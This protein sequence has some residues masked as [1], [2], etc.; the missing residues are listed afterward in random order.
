[1][2]QF[3]KI[4]DKDDSDDSHTIIN[5]DL[6]KSWNKNKMCFTTLKHIHHFYNS[7]CYLRKIYLRINDP[8]FKIIK[9]GTN[10]PE[11]RANI[12][13]FG[14]KYEL[15]NVDTIKKFNLKL[16]RDLMNIAVINQNID[17][18]DL[19]KNEGF[20]ISSISDDLI[21]YAIICNCVKSLSWFNDNYFFV[22][23]TEENI[24]YAA[25]YNLIDLLIWFKNNDCEIVGTEKATAYLSDTKIS[26]NN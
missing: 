8:E 16:T 15:C 13:T 17:V 4:T 10:I 24:E 2:P 3:F 9:F 1:M 7:G 12:V 14:K 6:T 26:P 23:C 5:D 20:D 18:L 19:F 11:W 25:Q 21:F 22:N